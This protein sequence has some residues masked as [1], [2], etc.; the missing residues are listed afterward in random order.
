MKTAY[1]TT[2]AKKQWQKPDF[3]ILDSVNAPS[4][5]KD[6]KTH[7][8][9]TIQPSIQPGY[10]TAGGDMGIYIKSFVS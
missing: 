1:T 3:Y 2:P 4:T 5:A 10:G 8:E 6:L 7:N 9:G